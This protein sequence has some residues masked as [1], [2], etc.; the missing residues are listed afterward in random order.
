MI[1]EYLVYLSD[2]AV[3]KY[4]YSFKNITSP[5]GMKKY[6]KITPTSK[7]T[8]EEKDKMVIQQATTLSLKEI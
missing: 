3:N 2:C 8:E 7:L 6:F 4:V 5:S 1:L